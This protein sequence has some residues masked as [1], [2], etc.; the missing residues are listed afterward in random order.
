VPAQNAGAP[1]QDTQTSAEAAQAGTNPPNGQKLVPLNVVVR[2]VQP[3]QLRY[4]ASYDTERGVGGIFDVSQH[5]WLGGARV[6][7]LQ[8]RYD[9]Q[10]HD[11]RIYINQPALRYLPFKTTGSVYIREDR[12]PPTEIT[13]AFNASRKGASIQQEVELL[14]SYVWNWGYRYERARTFQPVGDVIIMSD[15]L[16]VSPL[17][18]T[19]TRE[20]RDDALDATRGSF[21]SH[22][23]AFSPGWLGSDLPY[24]K[25]FAQYFRYFPLRPPTRK[26]FT[27]EILRPRLV[28]ATG[29]RLGLAKG[30]GGEVP[31]SERFFAGGSVSMRGFAQNAVGPIGADLVPTGGNGLIVINNE[32]RAPLF[33]RLDG[34]IFTDI[35]NVFPLISDI[36]FDLRQSA[37]VG[38]RV[39]TPWF[40]LR[41]DYGRVLDPRPGERSGRFYFSIGQAF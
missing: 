34:V 4:G 28:F 33:W 39:R 31:I 3:L 18:S 20:T 6:V 14:N 2:E 26:P 7:G 41:G 19:L 38:V 8:A 22:A 30:I 15:P 13:R 23:F 1:A 16:T 37:G 10:L 36:S 29:V 40:L 5:N 17:T 27:N 32:L 12:N 21:L 24:M 35:G 9:R 25:Y 11:G